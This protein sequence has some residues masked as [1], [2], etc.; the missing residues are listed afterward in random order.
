MNGQPRVATAETFALAEGPIWDP[1]QRLVRWVDIR[2]GLVFAGALEADGSIDVVE[3]MTFPGTMGA[4]GLS[5]GGTWVGANGDDL[6]EI[7][8]GE[9]VRRIPVLRSAGA[10]RFND[11]KPDARGRFLVGTLSLAGPSKTEQLLLVETDGSWR[12]IDDDL[13]LSNGIAWSVDGTRLYSVDTMRQRVYARRYD[14]ATG[15][16]G[17]REV[18]IEGAEGYPDGLC[19]DAADHLWVAMWGIGQVHRYSPAGELVHVI[20][21]PAPHTS[22]VAFAG[23]HLETLVITTASDD[24]TADQLAAYPLSGRLFTVVPGVTGF[25]LPPW[26]GFTLHNET[27]SA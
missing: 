9:I 1:L 12:V 6:V 19:V 20:E 22:S 16:T 23:P 5:A 4:I 10:R 18:L 24:L 27:E 15:D 25:P 17:R 11:G 8:D 26:G 14:S 21:V 2:R 13:T 3:R 7:A